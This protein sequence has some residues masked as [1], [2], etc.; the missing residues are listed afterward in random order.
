[1]RTIRPVTLLAAVAIAAAACSSPAEPA[2]LPASPEATVAA[3]GGASAKSP[4]AAPAGR[5]VS[6]DVDLALVNLVSEPD[7]LTADQADCVVKAISVDEL[8]LVDNFSA[9]FKSAVDAVANPQDM[10]NGAVIF[11]VLLKVAPCVLGGADLEGA[12]DAA[13]EDPI[14]CSVVEDPC[15]YGDDAALDALWDSC[16]D[17]DMMKCDKLFF[18]AEF[19]TIYE[20]FGDTCGRT[21]F[22]GGLCTDEPGDTTEPAPADCDNVVGP[23]E[24]GDDD[25][26]DALWDA[27]EAGDGEACDDLFL[28]APSGT[29]YED[30]G[31]S[32]GDRGVEP[33]CAD[34]YS[35]SS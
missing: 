17:G 11:P 13:S 26:L 14:D 6:G 27:C 7:P 9:D 18:D 2:A 29:R 34:V 10:E 4:T 21:R 25:E 1:M 20:Q 32:C 19:G 15:E 22:D 3:G 24:Y 30:F 5:T 12:L 35:I 33:S 8:G 23:C 31:N 16:D 28:D